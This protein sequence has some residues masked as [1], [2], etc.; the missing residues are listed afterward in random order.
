MTTPRDLR[1]F[2]DLPRECQ[3]CDHVRCAEVPV[4]HGGL[5]Y[6]HAT[7]WECSVLRAMTEDCWVRRREARREATE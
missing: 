3:Q 6:V 7:R 5:R 4:P 2:D 1:T